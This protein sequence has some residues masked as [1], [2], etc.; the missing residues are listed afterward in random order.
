MASAVEVIVS[1]LSN[2]NSS[3]SAIAAAIQD[4]PSYKGRGKANVDSLIGELAGSD[5]PDKTVWGAVKEALKAPQK[6]AVPSIPFVGAVPNPTPQQVAAALQPQ[7]TNKKTTKKAT[8]KVDR[9]LPVYRAAHRAARKVQ[10]ETL[11]GSEVYKK[12]YDVFLQKQGV[13]PYYNV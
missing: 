3:P 13:A 6:V 4:H 10:L 2:N 8:K 11:G 7:P 5:R 12:A 9:S 1:V